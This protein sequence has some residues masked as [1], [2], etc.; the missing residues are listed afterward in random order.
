MLGVLR[1]HYAA[2]VHAITLSRTG[3]LRWP[4]KNFGNVKYL[5]DIS[6]IGGREKG[7]RVSESN[8]VEVIHRRGHNALI[9]VRFQG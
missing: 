6:S 3:P 8:E 1:D 4:C 7:V 5:T 9:N 2:L